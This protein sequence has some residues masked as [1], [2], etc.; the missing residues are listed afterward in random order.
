MS[1]QLK[2]KSKKKFQLGISQFISVSF[3]RLQRLSI[4]YKKCDEY[5]FKIIP[6]NTAE[7]FGPARDC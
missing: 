2:K 3:L 1:A 7:M 5:T 4:I 6:F